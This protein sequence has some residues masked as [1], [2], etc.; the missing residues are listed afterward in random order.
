VGNAV[1]A[2]TGDYALFSESEMPE[3]SGGVRER[4]PI[5]PTGQAGHPMSLGVVLSSAKRGLAA[6]SSDAGAGLG[7]A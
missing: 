7:A 4:L 1:P 2:R 6:T 5:Q 3:F